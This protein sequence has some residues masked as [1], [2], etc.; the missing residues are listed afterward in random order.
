[1]KKMVFLQVI[2]FSGFLLHAQNLDQNLLSSGGLLF[3]SPSLNLSFT[4]GESVV[5]TFQDT[6]II[7]AQGFQQGPF[8][9]ASVVQHKDMGIEIKLFPNPVDDRLLLYCLADL[10]EPFYYYLQDIS[11]K[12]I[13]CADIHQTLTRIDFRDLPKGVYILS[14]FNQ[15]GRNFQTYRIIKSK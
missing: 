10:K 2:V 5:E 12:Y 7:L 9:F 14:I 11:G 15:E 3:K 1:M 13:A 6:G 8:I 4:L